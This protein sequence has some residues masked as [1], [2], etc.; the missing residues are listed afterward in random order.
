MFKLVVDAGWCWSVAV[1]GASR[2]AAIEWL[3]EYRHPEADRR[4]VLNEYDNELSLSEL[5]A[6]DAASS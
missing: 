5:E 4:A 1:R 2:E 3:R 6:Q